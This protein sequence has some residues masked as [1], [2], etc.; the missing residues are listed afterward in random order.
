MLRD[1]IAGRP[2]W[3]IAKHITT[4]RMDVFT[5]HHCG[6]SEALAVFSL[7]RELRCSSTSDSQRP[8]G[9]GREGKADLGGGAGVR[10]LRTLLGH[11]EGSA[12][13]GGARGR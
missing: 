3:L 10:A 4:S 5:T 13:P 2:P 8:D 12:G 6:D 7:K 11:K 1:K 9:E